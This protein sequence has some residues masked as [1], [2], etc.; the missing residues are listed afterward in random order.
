MSLALLPDTYGRERIV[1]KNYLRRYRKN[2]TGRNS[3]ARKRGE[4]THGDLNNL[5]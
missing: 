3:A 5:T 4:H 2:E 1:S